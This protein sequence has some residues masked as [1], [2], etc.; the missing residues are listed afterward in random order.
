[1][2][3]TLTFY[4]TSVVQFHAVEPNVCGIASKRFI[5]QLHQFAAWQFL[6][7]GL[8]GRH[9]LKGRL[10]EKF[11]PGKLGLND[12]DQ[13]GPLV[14]GDGKACSEVKMGPLVYCVASS[15]ALDQ[16]N[17]SIGIVGGTAGEC[18]TDI[19]VCDKATSNPS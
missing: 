16:A 13:F 3:I 15:S 11:I 6:H 19:H 2:R 7:N 1:M 4:R 5:R 18:F 17:G 9:Q 8:C 10:E 12:L 14:L